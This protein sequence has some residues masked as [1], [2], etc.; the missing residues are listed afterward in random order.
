MTTVAPQLLYV[1]ETQRSVPVWT[2]S[3]PG[4]SDIYIERVHYDGMVPIGTKK[5]VW[6]GNKRLFTYS[7]AGSRGQKNPTVLRARDGF[8]VP[9]SLYTS[10]YMDDNEDINCSPR[11]FYVPVNTVESPEYEESYDSDN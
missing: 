5:P 4:K 9:M 10:K 11:P 2:F 6:L 7:V 1:S 3:S 8:H